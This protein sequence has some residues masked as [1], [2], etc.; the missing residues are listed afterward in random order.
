[1]MDYSGFKFI[2]NIK[3]G[4]PGD[5]LDACKPFVMKEMGEWNMN[6]PLKITKTA[7]FDFGFSELGDITDKA[8]SIKRIKSSIIQSI[9]D[10][11]RLGRNMNKVRYRQLLKKPHK[12]LQRIV[13]KSY[14]LHSMN[15]SAAEPTSDDI[16]DIIDCLWLDAE[17]VI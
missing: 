16:G 1:M 8:K 5:I 6:S 13:L 3:E 17:L 11:D 2:C 10:C 12:G 4:I 14:Y 7:S 9:M 15:L